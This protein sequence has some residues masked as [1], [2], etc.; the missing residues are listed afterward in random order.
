MGEPTQAESCGI[1]GGDG[2]LVNS[3]GSVAKCPSC[4]GSGRRSEDTG[5]HDVTKT[6]ASHHQN[7][8]QRGAPAAK[9]TWPTSLSG[10]ALATEIRDTPGLGDDVKLRLTREIMEHEETH[11]ACTQTFVK[12]MRKQFRPQ[13]KG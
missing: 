12:K 13:P 10:I 3:F 8:N 7:S 1:C 11:P 6:K 4:H 5:F 9:P 2:R